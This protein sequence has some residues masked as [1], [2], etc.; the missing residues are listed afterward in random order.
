MEG[1]SLIQMRDR[2]EMFCLSGECVNVPEDR[3][4][5]TWGNAKER[6]VEKYLL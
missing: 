5:R 4:D 6:A 1:W 3:K 2:R